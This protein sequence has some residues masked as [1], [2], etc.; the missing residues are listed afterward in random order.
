MRQDS[1]SYRYSCPFGNTGRICGPEDSKARK[2]SRMFRHVKAGESFKL[3][4]I[5]TNKINPSRPSITALSSSV[6]V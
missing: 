4:A 2:L 1:N 6:G 3:E 5:V